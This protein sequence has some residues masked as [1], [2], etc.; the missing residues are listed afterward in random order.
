MNADEIIAPTPWR[1]Y[2]P[3][4]CSSP[5]SATLAV[6]IGVL[7]KGYRSCL[8][9]RISRSLGPGCL[10][11]PRSCVNTAVGRRSG[12]LLVILQRLLKRSKKVFISTSHALAGEILSRVSAL[13]PIASP[14]PLETSATTSGSSNGRSPRRWPGTARRIVRLKIL[15]RRTLHLNCCIIRRRRLASQCPQRRTDHREPL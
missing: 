11:C 14:R 7:L 1:E 6:T 5:L 8:K 9:W 3:L 10:L 13:M 12:S 2:D 4:N 15:N